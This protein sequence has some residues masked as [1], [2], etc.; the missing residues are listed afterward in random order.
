MK[1]LVKSRR[2][3]VAPGTEQLGEAEPPARQSDRGVQPLQG[4]VGQATTQRG[5]QYRLRVAFGTGGPSPQQN[6][7]GGH[8]NALGD[9]PEP[10]RH[11]FGERP[12]ALLVVLR[13]EAA[14]SVPGR[15]D[16]AR[17][18]VVQKEADQSV[19][20]KT[21]GEMK[22]SAL[23]TSPAPGCR[24]RPCSRDLMDW[25]SDAARRAPSGSSPAASE[26]QPA[27]RITS[28]A[29]A[30]L[31]FRGRGPPVGDAQQGFQQSEPKRPATEPA[32]RARAR[33]NW[34]PIDHP[35][36]AP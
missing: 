20:P 18:V 12:K 3:S 22:V 5:Y 21:G 36:P 19:R 34:P 35:R 23:P 31:R 13:I 26:V 7:V 2:P 14:A 17:R 24:R 15:N 8:G 11:R 27:S 1:L 28:V 33:S 6:F 4:G 9:G 16:R 30:P 32:G 25:K 29:I 10:W